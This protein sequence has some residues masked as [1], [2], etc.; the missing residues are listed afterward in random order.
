[1]PVSAISLAADGTSRVQLD[2]NGGLAFV[3]VKVGLSAGGFAEVDPLSDT[4]KPG[5]LVVV[6]YKSAEMPPAK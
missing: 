6:G 2:R 4:L 3:T 5:Q 1:V